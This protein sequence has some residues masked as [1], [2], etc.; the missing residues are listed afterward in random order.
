MKN[1]LVIVLM[2]FFS[3]PIISMQREVSAAPQSP[4]LMGIP[5]DIRVLIIKD[6]TTSKS[7]AE[8]IDALQN[9]SKVNHKFNKL[10]NDPN[11]N[12]S[13]IKLLSE[14]WPEFRNKTVTEIMMA[15]R[16]RSPGS[17]LWLKNKIKANP[18]IEETLTNIFVYIIGKPGF[19]LGYDFISN[20]TEEIPYKEMK[21]RLAFLI[22]AGFDPNQLPRFILLTRLHNQDF[23]RFLIKAGFDI[24]SISKYGTTLL[25]NAKTSGKIATGGPETYQEV[26]FLRSLGA[27]TAAELKAEKQNK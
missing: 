25:D 21:E 19:P 23:I 26:Q 12:D 24:N 13:L 9:L 8:A 5:N 14:R 2:L 20:F 16:L 15:V 18:E 10:L 4:T 22:A 1:N 3:M 17:L 6:L 11:I 7:I 27:K